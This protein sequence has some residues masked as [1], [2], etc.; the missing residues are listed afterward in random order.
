[1][2]GWIW[3]IR[4]SLDSSQKVDGPTL[5]FLTPVQLSPALGSCDPLGSC[6]PQFMLVSVHD[7]HLLDAQLAC[8]LAHAARHAQ[9]H[10]IACF[11][12]FAL[13]PNCS[14]L[15]TPCTA[16]CVGAME[17]FA[18]H[19]NHMYSLPCDLHA[20]SHRPVPSHLHRLA[21][22]LVLPC[23]HHLYCLI[24]YRTT[25]VGGALPVHAHRVTAAVGRSDAGAGRGCCC[26][27]P[28]GC[29]SLVPH[30]QEVSTVTLFVPMRSVI[31]DVDFPAA[32]CLMT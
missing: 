20:R 10:T 23:T 17:P 5:S 13:P 8:L 7:A 19:P 18:P 29:G 27:R 26:D 14:V 15:P 12:L 6:W 11:V 9:L 2:D 1:M 21:H 28:A 24:P 22:P 30:T 31:F 32:W 4:G 25:G 16:M 3:T